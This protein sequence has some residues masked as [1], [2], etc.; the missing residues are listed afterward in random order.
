[1]N[2]ALLLSLG[3]IALVS[4]L[5][6]RVYFH[7]LSH[8][9]G[10]TLAKLTY[11]YEWYYDLYQSGQFTFKLRALHQKYGTKHPHLVN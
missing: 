10:P 7:P 6:Y 9:P 4:F 3:L 8:I 5:V 1:M 2:S 11:L